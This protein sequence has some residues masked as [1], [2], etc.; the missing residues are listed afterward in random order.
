MSVGYPEFVENP[1]NRCPVVLLLDTSGSMS[2]EPIRE[3]NRGIGAFKEDVIKDSQASLSV[4]L[5]MV[6]FGGSVNLIQDFTSIYEFTPP[7]LEA[8]NQTPMGEAIEYGLHL[9]ETRKL[10]YKENGVSYYRPWVFLITDESANGLL[11]VCGT[12]SKRSRSTAATMFFCCW[13]TRCGYE[14]FKTNCT[15]RTDAA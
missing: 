15:T 5:A 7:Q 12:T 3:L 10:I 8:N 11:A 1:E 9:L 4:E 13:C 2:G 6:T 14:Y